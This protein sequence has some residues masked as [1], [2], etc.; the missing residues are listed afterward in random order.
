VD[1]HRCQPSCC[2]RRHQMSVARSAYRSAQTL[3][4]PPSRGAN[5]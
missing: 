2:C 3:R 4:P 5:T 1:T